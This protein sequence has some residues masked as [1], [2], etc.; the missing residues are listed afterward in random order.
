MNLAQRPYCPHAE[1]LT[2]RVVMIRVAASAICLGTVLC[3][4]FVV[5]VVVQA[6]V[7]ALRGVF[8]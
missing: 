6:G 1:P 3:A 5:V 4:L 2:F 8:S 7:D